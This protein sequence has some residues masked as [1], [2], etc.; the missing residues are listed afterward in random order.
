MQIDNHILYTHGGVATTT[1]KIIHGA[2]RNCR[3]PFVLHFADTIHVG[4]RSHLLRSIVIRQ[5]LCKNAFLQ[6]I[7]YL[8]CQNT[9]KNLFDAEDFACKIF[10]TG[11]R[12]LQNTFAIPMATFCCAKIHFCTTKCKQNASIARSVNEP[13]DICLAKMHFCIRPM[14]YFLKFIIFF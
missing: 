13:A 11:F 7:F 3:T 9:S 8:S 6:R 14:F 5:L 4:H 1:Q 12:D 2:S 10:S